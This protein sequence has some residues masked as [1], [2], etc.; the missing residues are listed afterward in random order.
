MD[1]VI[2]GVVLGV[3]QGVSEWLPISSKTQVLLASTILL[4][5]SFS[6][7]YSFGLF[8]EVGTILA[9]IVY[10]RREIYGVLK[11]LVGR[12]SQIDVLLLKYLVVSTLVTGAIGVP[13]YVAIVN[14]VKGPTIG[15]P[16]TILGLVLIVDGLVIH[17]SRR[18]Y[19]PKKGIKDISLRDMA[20]VGLAQGLAALP[21]VSRS[22]MTT[23]ALLLLGYKPEE[24]FKLSFIALIPSALGAIGVTVLLSKDV[25]EKALGEVGLGALGIS[26]VVA[27]A[28]SLVLI[29]GLLKFARTKKVLLLVFA[30]G[31]MALA[32]G[33]LSTL[34]GVG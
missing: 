32:S 13:I 2:V 22:G 6:V 10:F 25:V 5:L 11:A 16:M 26:V 34:T 17:F 1:A 27:T 33:I 31:A 21:G 7:G 19:R 14:L 28:V 23:S 8:M 3:V 4:G 20:L 9:A 18:T 29:D 30:L 12:G 24:A 15:V